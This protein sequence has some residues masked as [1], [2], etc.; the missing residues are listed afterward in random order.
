MDMKKHFFIGWFLLSSL[1]VVAKVSF[2]SVIA[3]NMVLQQKSTVKLW[4]K[5]VPGSEVS[6]IPSWGQKI[7]KAKADHSGSWLTTVDTPSAGGPYEIVF[8]DGEKTVLGNILI[9]EVWLC[10][11]QSNM[12]MPL[13]GFG[14][15]PVVDGNDCIARA[16]KSVPIRM[17]TTANKHS[18]IPQDDCEGTW[19][20]HTSEAVAKCSATAYFFGRYLQEI[21]EVPVGLIVSSW[22]GSKIEAWMSRS[23]L[24]AFPEFDLDFLKDNRAVKTPVHHTPC[25]LYHAKLY[26]LLNYTIKGAIWYQGESNRNNPALYERLFPAF[27]K[28]L[29]DSFG[30]GDFP[31][32]YVQIA[33]FAYENPDMTAGAAIREAQLKG[34]STIPN[35]GMVVTLDIGESNCIHPARKKEVGERLAYWALARAYDKKGIGYEGPV[36]SSMTVEGGKAL[37]TFKNV[38]AKGVGPLGK[39]LEGFEVAGNDRKFHP[40]SAYVDARLG[41]VVVSCSEV[42]QPIAVRYAYKNYAEA[43]LFNEWGLPASSFRTDDW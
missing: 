36:Y 31:F 17:F 22:G 29:R 25:N 32:Y 14:G 34:C 6:I 1:A 2:P 33:P 35:S 4:G 41:K 10:A 27:V 37:L 8:D 5:S 20:E 42:V 23:S 21:L 11:G 19:S 26:P 43:S 28:D 30:Q 3:D 7:Y 16:K 24:A 18:R 9:G 39:N 40:A 15:Q 12:E 38:S 13:C